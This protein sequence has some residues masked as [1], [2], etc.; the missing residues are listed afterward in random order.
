MVTGEPSTLISVAYTTLPTQLDDGFGNSIGITFASGDGILWGD[1]YTPGTYTT[2]N[3]VVGQSF[4]LSA[5]DPGEMYVGIRGTVDPP[6][7]SVD[8]DYTGTVVLTVA[9]P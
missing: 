7:V 8:G 5:A 2:F 9:Y 1:T 3:P 4:T 6:A